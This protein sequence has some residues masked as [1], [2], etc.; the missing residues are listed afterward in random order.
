MECEVR[1]LPRR[2]TI[3][4]TSASG[5]CGDVEAEE[6]RLV[7]AA[8]ANPRAF[9]PLYRAYATPVYRYLHHQTGNADDAEDLTA[10]TF[11]KTLD[12]LDRYEDRGRFAVWLFSIARHT[13]RDHQRRRRPHL[14]VALVAATLAD[15]APPPEA[16]LP[17]A[18]QA[19]ELHRLLDQL[20]PDQREALTLRFF[21]GLSTRDV[22]AILVRSEG[23]VKML[24]L[25]AMDRLRDHYRREGHP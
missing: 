20:P 13:L 22:A 3:P 12:S 1:A 2:R 14:D 4:E 25:R 18:E 15:P 6:R 8:R 10:V 19:R 23:A 17:R 5:P 9:A 21:G 11:G 7:A 24:V 16:W